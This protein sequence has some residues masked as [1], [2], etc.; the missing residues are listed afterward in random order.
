MVTYTLIFLKGAPLKVDNLFFWILIICLQSLI[1][2]ASLI[3]LFFSH[4]CLLFETMAVQSF[5]Y[6]K[7]MCF[8]Q[9][10]WG[11]GWRSYSL[12]SAECY[13]SNTENKQSDRKK[14]FFNVKGWIVPVCERYSASLIKVVIRGKE[15]LSHCVG[16]VALTFDPPAIGCLRCCW[17][18]KWIFFTI[19]FTLILSCFG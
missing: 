13:C 5:F 18:R 2:N 11:N 1:W 8:N 17:S 4:M 19:L 16:A 12:A 9:N 14:A 10:Q 6:F 7:V 3:K 15:D